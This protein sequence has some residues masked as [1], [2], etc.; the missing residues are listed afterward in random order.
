MSGEAEPTCSLAD[1]IQTLKVNLG[2]LRSVA[3]RQWVDIE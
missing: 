2:V 1:G 3:T